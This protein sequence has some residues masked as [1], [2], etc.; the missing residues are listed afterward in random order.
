MPFVS[1][2][3]RPSARTGSTFIAGL[4]MNCAAK[5]VAGRCV[6]V[7]RRADLFGHAGVHHHH[8]VGQRHRLDLIVGDVERGHAELALQLP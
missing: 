5:T 2:T 7:E 8:P 3:A 1:R 6:D 4:P